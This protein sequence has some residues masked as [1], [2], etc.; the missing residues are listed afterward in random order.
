M[1]TKEQIKN[2]IDFACSLPID[3]SLFTPLYY[4]YGSD[5][6][7][8]AI[9]EGKITK[10]DGYFLKASAENGL[11]HFTSSELENYCNDAV[12]RF[13]FRPSYLIKQFYRSIMR[14]DL[15]VMKLGLHNVL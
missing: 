15:G 8:E 7:N 14:K 5:L 13:Y 12:R 10:E 3:I 4:M 1:E 6:W 2:T 11:G 9:N